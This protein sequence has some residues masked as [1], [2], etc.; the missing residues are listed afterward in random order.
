MN[1]EIVDFLKKIEAYLIGC[2]IEISITQK[3]MNFLVYKVM[4]NENI[5]RKEIVEAVSSRLRIM[6]NEYVAN[7]DIDEQRKQPYVMIVCGVNGAGKTTTIGKM[8]SIF[9]KNNYDVMVA[10]CDTYRPA[11][12]IQLIDCSGLDVNDL[13]YMAKETDVP[14]KIAVKAYN[15]AVER[16]K[17]ILII[18]TSGRLHNNQNLMAELLK[19]KYKLH[20]I[21]FYIPNDVV[22]IVDAS[23][24][25]NLLE[26]AK[27]YNDLIGITGIIA[28]KL[29]ITKKPGIILSICEKFNIKIFGI[30]DG[31]GIN[32][33]RELEPKSFAD[34]IL[35][36][37]NDIM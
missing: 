36:D 37:I 17:D 5:S 33:I 3:I 29:D 1:K 8:V 13:I 20:E 30:C 12:D 16:G 4:Q 7:I 2:N 25:Y 31:E 18:D 32:K 10:E 14:Y 6:A 22:L 26:Q 21:S 35:S 15:T 28:T 19:I 34:A 23:G 9:K 24:G 11:T 27:M